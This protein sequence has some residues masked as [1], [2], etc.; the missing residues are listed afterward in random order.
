MIS[1]NIKEARRIKGITQKELG[2]VLGVS[3]S[4]IAGYESGNATP[5]AEKL[6]MIA[7]ATDTNIEW[8]LDQE[9]SDP[10]NQKKE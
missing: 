1:R 5:T 10:V 8:L 6:L 9:I 7:K 4:T 3:H 2:D